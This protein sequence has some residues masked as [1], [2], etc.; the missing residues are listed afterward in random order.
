MKGIDYHE[1]FRSASCPGN[2]NTIQMAATIGAGEMGLGV[3]Q[4][5]AKYGAVIV[6]GSNPVSS[7]TVSYAFNS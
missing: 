1:N 3:N 5:L 6:A 2:S 7:S 4:A